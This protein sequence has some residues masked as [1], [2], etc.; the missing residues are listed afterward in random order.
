[1][2]GCGATRTPSVTP[3]VD[4]GSSSAQAP[5]SEVRVAVDSKPRPETESPVPPANAIEP[6]ATQP[7]SSRGASEE[8]VE[9]KSVSTIT[10]DAASAQTSLATPATEIAAAPPAA[11]TTLRGGSPAA[12]P[13]QFRDDP[14]GQLQAERL[15]PPRKV[16]LPN[17]P[18]VAEPSRPAPRFPDVTDR[19][20]WSFATPLPSGESRS[21]PFE[22][23]PIKRVLPTL[24]RPQPPEFSTSL[25]PEQPAFSY[26][27]RTYVSS[28]A[29][30]EMPPLAQTAA[31]FDLKPQIHDD[32]GAAS[33]WK[34]LL[35]PLAFSDPVSPPPERLMIP[36]PFDYLRPV[37]L[38]QPLADS[39][40][41]SV[42]YD[43]P[44]P[45]TLPVDK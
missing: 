38:R 22:H 28:P 6:T 18:W 32:P 10:K 20:L 37:Q 34:S 24:D 7:P 2:T 15:P 3:S 35:S 26:V 11:S 36:D 5:S 25:V 45:V 23:P 31:P 21:F 40:T 43:R 17:P 27:A 9:A 42:A 44:A 12:A 16:E 1:M 14:A 29:P 39:H 4:E 33:A 19:Q 13:F 8:L 30:D 41:P